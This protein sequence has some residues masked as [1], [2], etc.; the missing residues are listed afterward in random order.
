MKVAQL[1]AILCDPLGSS[2][3]RLL[4]P[5]GFSRQGYY[6]GFSCP[7]PGDLPNSGIKLR[8]LALQVDSLPT[9]ISG[10]PKNTGVVS[11]GLTRFSCIAGGFFN[12]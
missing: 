6:S 12:N 4:S 2:S 3:L 8:S 7:S 11:Q 10:K 1:C 5:W 9:Q